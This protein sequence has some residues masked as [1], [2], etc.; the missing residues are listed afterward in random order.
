MNHVAKKGF[1]LIELMLAMSFVAALLIAV[2][3]TVIQIAAIYNRGITLKDVN[4]VGRAISTDIQRTIASGS[5]FNIAPGAGSR[6]IVQDWGGRLC[7]GQYSYIWNYGRNI[8]TGDSNQLNTYSNSASSIRFIKVLDPNTSYCTDPA[9]K[10]DFTNAVELLDTDVQN[11]HDLAIHSFNITSTSIGSDTAYDAKT[12]QRIYNVEFLIG[13]N[14][15][16]TLNFDQDTG[17]ASCKAPSEVGSD[18]QYCSINQFNIAAR[19][20]N[21][22]K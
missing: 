18:P 1:T 9:A 11:K 6:Y 20:G 16:T 7:L 8:Q 14:D 15:Q 21:V 17:L 10:I 13:T 12:G 3:M 22:V 5:A 4:Q 2:A 19:A